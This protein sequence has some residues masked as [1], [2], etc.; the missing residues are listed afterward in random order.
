[1]DPFKEQVAIIIGGGTGIG[2]AISLALSERGATVCLIGRRAH[3]LESVA[4]V[5]S[6][7]GGLAKTYAIDLT[8]DEDF[9]HWPRE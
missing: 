5:V 6:A 7:S 8:S 2:R 9:K 3:L 4:E 1:M